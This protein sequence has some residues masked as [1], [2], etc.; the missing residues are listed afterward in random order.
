MQRI[1]FAQNLD[2]WMRKENVTVA[3]LAEAMECAP[4]T[5]NRHRQG[6]RFPRPEDLIKY[7]DMM[8]I[9]LDRMILDDAAFE[10]EES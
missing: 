9:T 8:D 2:A 6:T 3:D 1:F 4:R 5:I 7:R 10:A